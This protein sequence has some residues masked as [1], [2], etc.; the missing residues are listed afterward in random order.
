VERERVQTEQDL[1]VAQAAMTNDFV[2]LQ[3]A[4]GLGWIPAKDSGPG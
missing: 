1:A 4:L 3:K 2:S